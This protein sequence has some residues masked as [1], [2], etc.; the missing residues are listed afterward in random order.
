M[1]VFSATSFPTL[2]FCCAVVLHS[3]CDHL[4]WAAFGSQGDTTKSDVLVLE[5][6]A[7]GEIKSR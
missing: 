6:A 5:T 7:L 2:C 1:F 4:V 3:Y